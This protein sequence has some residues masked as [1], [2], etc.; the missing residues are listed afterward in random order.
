MLWLILAIVTRLL[1]ALCNISD[2]YVSR[3]IGRE[4]T[5]ASVILFDLI[6]LPFITLLLLLR[7]F[8][9]TLLQ[10]DIYPWMICGTLAAFM[11]LFPYLR[12]LQ[13]DEARNVAPLHEMTPIF[14]MVLGWGVLHEMMAMQ[15]FFGACIVIISGFLFM[16]D[17]NHNHF[18]LK[19]F[20]LMAVSAFMFS[21][22]QLILRHLSLKIEVWDIALGFAIVSFLKGVLLLLCLPSARRH[23]FVSL[24]RKNRGLFLAVGSSEISNRLAA[25]CLIT[26]F[27]LAPTAGHV[28]ALSGTQPVFVMLLALLLGKLW[29]DHYTPLKWDRDT[30]VKLLVL[31]VMIGGKVLLQS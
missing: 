21:I 22:S 18:K 29:S 27:S 13:M 20:I 2:Q 3:Y 6:G 26:V 4:S 14:V 23:L 25:L 31:A 9:E 17:F 5:M 24:Q 30:Q 12:S 16:W 28:A 8:P 7:G 11:G 1:W 19:L 10:N 15:Q